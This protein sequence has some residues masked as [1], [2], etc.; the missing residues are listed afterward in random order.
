MILSDKEESFK[1]AMLYK[2][3]WLYYNDELTQKEIAEKLSISRLKVIRMLEEAR[4]RKIVS[5]NFSTVYRDKLAIEKE[6]ISKYG[7]KDVFVVPWNSDETLAEDLGQATALY[8]NDL[9]KDDSVVA[10]GYGETMGAFLKNLSKMTKKNI[11]VVSMTGGVTPYIRQIG[12][13]IVDL[14]HHLIPAPL[15]LSNKELTQ[16]LLAEPAVKKVMDKVHDADVIV[17]SLGGLKKN[18]TVIKTGIV[19]QIEFDTL[20]EKGAIGDI[21]MHF[22]DKDG[23]LV[24]SDFKDRIISTNLDIFKENKNTIVAAG[25]ED[26]VDMIK[27]A[28]SNGLVSVLI[29][30]ERTAQLL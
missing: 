20:A 1:D 25:G 27:T 22:I 17:T 12:N 7:V 11:S 23:N 5:F 15:L 28:L 6:L 13:G 8:L 4:K 14:K 9:I 3:S 21:L 29:I 24:E 2:V 19:S 26:K 10:V 16:A 18:A 30:D